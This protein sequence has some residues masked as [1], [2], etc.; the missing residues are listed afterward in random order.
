MSDAELIRDLRSALDEAATGLTLAPGA[1]DRARARGRRRAARGVLAVLPALALAAAGLTVVAGAG[2]TT[3]ATQPAQPAAYV[4]KHVVT[5]LKSV[6]D[7]VVR[8]Q[9]V[10]QLGQLVTSYDDP[11]AGVSMS[12]VDGKGDLAEYWTRTEQM[13]QVQR[14]ETVVVD[15]SSRTWLTEEFAGRLSAPTVRIPVK[16]V[17]AAAR[18]F[19]AQ[20]STA[21]IERAA[22]A[23]QFRV[24]GYS[25]M[26][27]LRVIE[28]VYT[29]NRPASTYAIRYWVDA[30]TYQPVELDY[31]PYGK[32]QS[33]AMSWIPRTAKIIQ[34][35][36][37]PQIPAGFQHL[38]K[39]TAPLAWPSG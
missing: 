17:P 35:T 23:G 32:S 18:T 9:S 2:R 26:G 28:L 14:I 5:T 27:G 11:A 7:Y 15:Y 30:R 36:A 21:Q 34:Y 16:A 38:A 13:G 33:V 22:L 29:D 3:P 19:V 4:T 8:T 37:K 10:N 20:A 39:E 25:L 6:S 24:A 12:V 1:A 31:P